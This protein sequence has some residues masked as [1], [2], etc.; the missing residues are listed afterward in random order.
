MK[1]ERL[2]L[3]ALFATALAACAGPSSRIKK[4][5]AEFDAYPA[6][7][8][9]KIRAGQVDVGFTDQQVALALGRPDRIYARKTAAAAQEVWAYGGAYGSRV[10]VGLGLGLGMGA[11][12]GFYGGGFSV[13]SDPGIDH[14]ERTRVVLQNGVVVSVESRQK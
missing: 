9:K 7:V 14:G 6:D 13:E 11:G 10:G 4:R 8:Q 2:L 5:Q 1:L 3:A 12:P